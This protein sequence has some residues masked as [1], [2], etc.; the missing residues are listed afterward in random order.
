MIS[1][2]CT[3]AGDTKFSEAKEYKQSRTWMIGN[4]YDTTEYQF[5]SLL[6]LGVGVAGSKILLRD[7]RL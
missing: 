1:V 5:F 7:T 4:N 2:C 3:P 6:I